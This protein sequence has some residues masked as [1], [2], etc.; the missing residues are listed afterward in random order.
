MCEQLSIDYYRYNLSNLWDGPA[1][2]I[3][4]KSKLKKYRNK[5]KIDLNVDILPNNYMAI[6]PKKK[7]NPN[8][9]TYNKNYI[10]NSFNSS[11]RSDFSDRSDIEVIDWIYNGT[12]YLLDKESNNIYSSETELVIGKRN[13]NYQVNKWYINNLN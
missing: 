4:N 10:I 9:I 13:Y 8:I 7:N 2:I 1:I 12:K 5:I 3:N 6:Y 11:D